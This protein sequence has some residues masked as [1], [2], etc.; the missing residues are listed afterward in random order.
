[1]GREKKKFKVNLCNPSR[2]SYIKIDYNLKQI[3]TIAR[4][5]IMILNNAFQF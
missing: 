4:L 2:N 5:K 1:M 3:S